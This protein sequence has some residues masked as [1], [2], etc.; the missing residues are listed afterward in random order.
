MK[1]YYRFTRRKATKANLKKLFLDP[2]ESPLNKAFAIFIGVFIGVLPIWGLQVISSIASAQFFKVNKPL[3]VLGS[4]INITPLFPVLVYFSLKIG[5]LIIG[6]VEALPALDEISLLTAKTYFWLY[7]I[8][9]VPIAIITAMVFGAITY[10]IA[11]YLKLSKGK[12]Q[13]VTVTPFTQ[14]VKSQLP[15]NMQ[16]ESL[17]ER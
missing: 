16:S 14:Q 4:H 17:I 9:C 6:S 1:K 12:L 2:N 5:A 10:F 13:P 11:V 15:L 7:V 8:G 3:A